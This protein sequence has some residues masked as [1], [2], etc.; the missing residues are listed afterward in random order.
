[1]KYYFKKFHIR[2]D[3]WE[4]VIPLLFQTYTVQPSLKCIQNE[5]PFGKPTSCNAYIKKIWISRRPFTYF[6]RT[7]YV[8]KLKSEFCTLTEILNL[9]SCRVKKKTIQK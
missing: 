8:D 2:S 1:M 4:N 7:T 6:Y 5:P 9:I 3:Q